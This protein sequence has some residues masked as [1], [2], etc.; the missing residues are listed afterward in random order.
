MPSIV[1]FAEHR[2]GRLRR[3]SLEAVAEARRLT[4]ALEASV[5]AVVVGSGVEGLASELGAHGA[6]TVHVFDQA[7]LA[8]YATEPY[9]RAGRS[10]PRLEAR[11][12]QAAA[13]RVQPLG[14]LGM[15]V[16]GVVLAKDRIVVEK[17][18]HGA[19]W[20]RKTR[21]ARGA[22]LQRAGVSG[23]APPHPPAH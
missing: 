3:P 11:L 20:R 5:H 14:A 9:A 7:E 2:D 15:A 10:E 19:L 21:A 18:A 6:D 1:T 13:H 22:G 16:P 12:P 8:S 23:G 17:D 4:G